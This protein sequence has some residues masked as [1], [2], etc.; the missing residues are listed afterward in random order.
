MYEAAIEARNFEALRILYEN[1]LNEENITLRRIAK[2]DILKVAVES[3]NFSLVEKV[4]RYDPIT[5][6]NINTNEI[7]IKAIILDNI[8]FLK[9]LIDSFILNSSSTSKIKRNNYNNY[10]NDYVDEQFTDDKSNEKCNIKINESQYDIKYLNFLLNLA[11]QNNNFNLVKFIIESYMYESTNNINEKDIHQEYPIITALYSNDFEIFKYLLD[12]GANY[13]TK[14]DN[15]LSLLL[16]AIHKN[17]SEF[18]EYLLLKPNLNINEKDYNGVSPLMKAVNQNNSSIVEQLINYSSKHKRYNRQHH[19][20]QHQYKNMRLDINEKD[21]KGNCP[22]IKAIHKNNFDIVFSLVNYGIKN[23]F[24]MNVKDSDGNTPL[25]ISYKYRYFPIFK[26]LT[27][28]LNINQKDATG[29]TVL[30]YA[31]KNGDLEMTRKLIRIG[32]DIYLKDDVGNSP[33]DLAIA[34]GDAQLLKCL[35]DKYNISL[36]NIH[37]NNYNG[38]CGNNNNSINNDSNDGNDNDKI[39]GNENKNDDSNVKS[40]NNN[41]GGLYSKETILISILKSK[42]YTLEDKTFLVKDLLEKG[43]NV[44]AINQEGFSALSYAL[45]FDLTSIVKTLIE[46]GA[47]INHRDRKGNSLLYILAK[48][49]KF[50]L[51]KLLYEEGALLYI[52]HKLSKFYFDDLLKITSYEILNYLYDHGHHHIEDMKK[53]ST[54]KY[55]CD[56]IERDDYEKFKL[57]VEIQGENF[58][59]D[60]VNDYGESLLHISLKNKSLEIFKYLVETCNANVYVKNESG[61]SLHEYN[62]DFNNTKYYY[63]SEEYDEIREILEERNVFY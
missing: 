16:L 12:H 29:H 61:K 43:T 19:D 38:D 34:S 36:M 39:S 46:N 28:Y 17:K 50:E 44:N 1:D 42:K 60:M 24:D 31:I 25:T 15:G 54:M 48:N 63:P 57:F 9:L 4:I 53:Y 47:D 26:Y 33:I 6:N 49:N 23:N 2:Y 59:P 55:Y 41:N 8:P 11:I 13:N 20:N 45:Q 62:N 14:N 52:D 18:V 5:Y 58:N 3:N 35:L 51:F 22:L 56:L 10:N 21:N 32:A 30:H 27:Q 7:L 37:C 40:N